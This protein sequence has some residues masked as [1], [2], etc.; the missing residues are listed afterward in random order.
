MIKHFFTALFIPPMWSL[1]FSMGTGINAHKLT[2]GIPL[3]M[4]DIILSNCISSIIKF[5]PRPGVDSF[6]NMY[7]RQIFFIARFSIL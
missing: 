2:F 7:L 1:Y 4:A 6:M 3:Y 5:L